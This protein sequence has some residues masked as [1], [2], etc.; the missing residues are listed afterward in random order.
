MKK[1]ILALSAI[2]LL[3]AVNSWAA[4]TINQSIDTQF[5]EKSKVAL[6]VTFTCTADASDGS[7]PATATSTDITNAIKGYY[8]YKLITNPG[9]TAPTANY[10]IT[11]TDEDGID[12]MGGNAMN[13]HTSN[14]ESTYPMI[15]T[16][17]F[18]QP[19]IGPI[20]LNIT[21]NSVNSAGIVIK[22]IFVK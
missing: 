15:G 9:T 20:T 3:L 19:I 8:L 6:V 22:A 12:I 14:S 7:F 1:G 10:D 5:L 11:I 18:A 21:N 13:R 2:L 16:Q 17:P 4:G